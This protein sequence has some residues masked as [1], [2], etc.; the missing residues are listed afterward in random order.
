MNK[1]LP[2]K[3]TAAVCGLLCKSCGI[4]IATLENN[5]ALLKGIAE[6]LHI[7]FEQVRCN[8]CR[9]NLLS[10]HCKTCYFREC[11]EKKEIGFCSDCN[12]YP[13]LHLKDFQTKMPHR[14]EL[15]QS[16]DRIKEVG[17]E[18]WYVENIARHS[19][20]KCNALNGWYDFTC[21]SCGNKPSSRFV[22]DNL[23]VLSRFKK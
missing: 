6:R 11:S 7:P 10:A 22:A 2:E 18:K 23:E 1:V 15:F 5:T 12:E 3:Q 17:W 21:R 20:T 4:Y 9:S 16:L 14:V 19:C 8:G 13:C